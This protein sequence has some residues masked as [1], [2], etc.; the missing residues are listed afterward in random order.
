MAAQ[1]TKKTGKKAF[2]DVKVPLTSTKIQLYAGSA[3]EL[4][5]RVVKIDLTRSLKGKSFEL[6]YKIKSN[7]DTLE[8]EPVSLWLAGSY[9][10]RMIRRGTDYV[11]DSFVVECKDGKA[12]VKPFMITRH[13]VSRVVRN[14]L[15]QNAKK[16]LIEYMKNRGT[17]ELFGDLM[18]N[19]IQKEMSL[20]LRK[21]YPLALCEVRVFEILKEEK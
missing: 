7:N 21:I 6:K 4:N 2:F 1:I 14:E 13:K 3:E 17:M 16:H 20:K 9:I 11:E 19:K 15:R 5:G 18:T 10:R 8:G 12:I